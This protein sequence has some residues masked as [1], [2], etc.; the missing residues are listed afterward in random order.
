MEQIIV[1]II[2]IVMFFGTIWYIVY[3]LKEAT[4]K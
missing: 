4:K 3:K 1:G 2:G